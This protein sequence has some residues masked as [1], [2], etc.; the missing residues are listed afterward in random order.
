[1]II[2]TRQISRIFDIEIGILKSRSLV[3]NDIVH[4][5]N[6]YINLKNAVEP[7]IKFFCESQ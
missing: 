2:I 5:F 6:E 3:S 7:F 4:S 1:M